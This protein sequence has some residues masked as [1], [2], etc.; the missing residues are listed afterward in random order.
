MA[1]PWGKPRRWDLGSQNLIHRGTG[2]S[3]FIGK[4]S[5]LRNTEIKK[6]PRYG[7]ADW[8]KSS[9]SSPS[10]HYGT[11]PRVSRRASV[12]APG[13]RAI[14]ARSNSSNS[15]D[16]ISR[17]KSF[18]A[19]SH[20]ELPRSSST[21]LTPGSVEKSPMTSQGSFRKKSIRKSYSTAT[22]PRNARLSRNEPANS[23]VRYTDSREK[24]SNS[25]KR[26]SSND[27]SLRLSPVSS[28]SPSR[29]SKHEISNATIRRSMET[30]E[31]HRDRPDNVLQT[32]KGPPISK[33]N[34]NVRANQVIRSSSQ[35]A[36]SK[37]GGRKVSRSKSMGVISGNHGPHSQGKD[38]TQLHRLSDSDNET[39][40]SLQNHGHQSPNGRNKS[41][42]SLRRQS[43]SDSCSEPSVLFTRHDYLRKSARGRLQ[44]QEN[45]RNLKKSPDIKVERTRGKENIKSVVP[46]QE[47]N[48]PM[49]RGREPNN[50]QNISHRYKIDSEDGAD[51]TLF[52]C[53]Q[54]SSESALISSESEFEVMRP[55][56]NIV[57]TE[58]PSFREIR[59]RIRSRDP[60]DIKFP[61]ARS[62]SPGRRHCLVQLHQITFN[63]ERPPTCM[64]LADFYKNPVM[65]PKFKNKLK[66]SWHSPKLKTNTKKGNR[67]KTSNKYSSSGRHRIS[68]SSDEASMISFREY[69]RRVTTNR[70][71]DSDMES[72]TIGINPGY[73]AK[74]PKK[75]I[76]ASK[77]QTKTT[78]SSESGSQND[79]QSNTESKSSLGADS[80]AKI[81]EM[82]YCDADLG[83]RNEF[84]EENSE[85]QTKERPGTSNNKL[86]TNIDAP[87]PFKGGL[88]EEEVIAELQFIIEQEEI[89]LE[90][91]TSSIS[92]SSIKEEPLDL[93]QFESHEKLLS[94]KDLN[95][96][97]KLLTNSLSEDSDPLKIDD[98]ALF[99]RTKSFSFMS[100]TRQEDESVEHAVDKVCLSSEKETNESCG[101]AVVDKFSGFS[102]ELI[103]EKPHVGIKTKNIP[104][105]SEKVKFESTVL[106]SEGNKLS[107]NNNSV[108]ATTDTAKNPA[109][110]EELELP[111]H[112]PLL[113]SE[114]VV[115]E[116]DVINSEEKEIFENNSSISTS[117]D[118]TD[119]SMNEEET[120]EP[121]R[122][123]TPRPRSPLGFI[124]PI[125]TSFSANTLAYLQNKK[126]NIT[127]PTDG[128]NAKIGAIFER[129]R[130]FDFFSYVTDSE[131]SPTD[132]E[133]D[134]SNTVQPSTNISPLYD[135]P[136]I[137][138]LTNLSTDNVLEPQD[139]LVDSPEVVDTSGLLPDQRPYYKTV[140]IDPLSPDTSATGSSSEDTSNSSQSESFTVS[141]TSESFHQ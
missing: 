31:K 134:V 136:N 7:P 122:T 106:N 3:S 130:P 128:L 51:D 102:R 120:P 88:N 34:M 72:N 49:R 48:S 94:D 115:S 105:K 22:L 41:K 87:E 40:N 113:E 89:D 64:E 39:Q 55:E 103:K 82:V 63:L 52:D 137:F 91:T 135:G 36:I 27:F 123:F 26:S 76:F 73:R 8:K 111:K 86:Q 35:S 43:E 125:R 85:I 15:T 9:S 90:N 110:V 54:I 100:S 14:L 129:S 62:I 117:S 126:V 133:A 101:V 78:V 18:A 38:K 80:M 44:A 112:G 97:I 2:I 10:S 114:K 138:T 17:S 60:R 121:V 70:T 20:R 77:Y 61:R 139:S 5:G 132:S 33:R 13:T 21:T 68:S 79:T 66:S 96:E 107:K 28:R 65:T 116:S 108:F 95:S 16:N 127:S 4:G 99:S 42:Y 29:E 118:K 141:N 57:I 45:S 92:M 124:R 84:I 47:R 69:E 83:N 6:I 109:F 71:S 46:Y 24:R 25:L 37:S 56:K 11:L 74:L 93:K 104:S 32:R 140:V 58:K 75:C 30:R 53:T 119:S 98:D 50:F 12:M 81:P 59:N 1:S 19:N 67:K 131:T 23:A